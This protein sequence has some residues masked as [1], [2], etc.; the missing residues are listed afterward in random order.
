MNAYDWMRALHILAVI[1]WMAAMLMYPRLLVYR[2]E[3][4]GDAR[5]EAAMDQAAARL[6]KIILNPSMILA[7]LL[8]LAI[9]GHGWAGYQA[10]PW[11]WAKIAAVLALSGLHGWYVG[12]GRK[13]ARGET[14]LTTKR[15]RMLSE[16]PFVI[17]IV[18]V[19]AVVVQPG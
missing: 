12:L 15:L 8:G 11:F 14:P 16:L 19:L 5:F 17:A 18:A 10:Q 3:A 6:R 1:A 7:W 2:M 13:V 9:A 4:A